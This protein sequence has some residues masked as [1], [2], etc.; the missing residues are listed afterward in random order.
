[1]NI[2]G[3]PEDERLAILASLE[4]ERPGLA[5]IVADVLHRDWR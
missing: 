4:A 1:M 3:M 5:S 2:E